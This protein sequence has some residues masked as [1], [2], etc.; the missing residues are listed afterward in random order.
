MAER[1]GRGG[2]GARRSGSGGGRSGG[3]RSS[4]AGSGS[5]GGRSAS[6]GGSGGYGSGRGSGA[7]SGGRSEAKFPRDDRGGTPR[8]KIK[9]T[10]PR[11][12][13]T[14]VEATARAAAPQV[15]A[16][17]EQVLDRMDADRPTDAVKLAGEAKALAS[18]S[19]SVREMLGM[20]LYHS[21]RYRDAIRE[22]QAY[23]RMSG[24]ADQNH[25]MADAHRALGSPEKAIPLVQEALASKIDEASRAEAA[26][27]GGAA[28]ADLGR[29]EEAL[30]ILRRF[31][32]REEQA[33][34]YDLRVWYVTGDVL[35]RAGRKREAAREFLRIIKHDPDAYDAAERASALA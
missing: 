13:V 1:R 15:I 29:Y 10:L 30:A 18:R 27:V 23:R 33:R 11:E 35:E 9:S 20:A 6:G 8:P 16:L 7:R 5:G 2:S 12:I 31:R 17:L 25:L 24:L 4:A 14:E 19:A 22:L 21:E 28:L 32:T 3:G 34:P 26:V